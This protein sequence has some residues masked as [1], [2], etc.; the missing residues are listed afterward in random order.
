MSD[1]SLPQVPG[2]R[3]V[4]AL[5][6]AGFIVRRQKGNHTLLVHRQDL[7]RRCVI[8]LH[9]SKPVKSGTLR[10]ILKGANISPEEFKALLR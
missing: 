9:G 3:V 1:F 6:E 8:P 5:E 10:A 2:Q 4:R 7:S